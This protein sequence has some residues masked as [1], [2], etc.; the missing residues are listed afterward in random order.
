MILARHDVKSSAKSKIDSFSQ[1]K[2]CELSCV[3]LQ[4]YDIVCICVYRS[5]CGDLNIFLDIMNLVLGEV[6]QRRVVLCGDFNLKFN[7]Q[8]NATIRFCDLL[9]SYGF[10]QTITS[11]TRGNSCIG[12]SLIIYICPSKRSL[13]HS[14]RTSLTHSRL[15]FR[16]KLFLK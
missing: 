12:P 16:R 6:L 5:P 3:Y 8:E 10:I 11:N 7:T 2:H 14:T 13:L 4:E 9:L 15:L 1:E